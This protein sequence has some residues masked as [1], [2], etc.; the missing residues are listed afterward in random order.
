MF[1][2][3]KDKNDLFYCG[4]NTWDKQ[5]RKA[6]IYTSFKMAV[7]MRDDIRFIE[8]DSFIITVD[9]IEGYKYNPDIY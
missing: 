2:A 4:Y 8:H 9:I 6:K 7:K 5:L 1:F 3:I